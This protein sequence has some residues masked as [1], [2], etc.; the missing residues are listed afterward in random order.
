MDK[1]LFDREVRYN[2]VLE[3]IDKYK[4]PV[5]CGKVNYPG[6]NKN[7]REVHKAF[8]ILTKL[9]MEAFTSE[10]V[11]SRIIAGS[12]GP[13]HIMVLRMNSFKAKDIAVSIEEN[14]EIGRVFDIDIYMENGMS[15]SR[16]DMNLA[17]RKCIICEEDSRI[18]TKLSRHSLEEVLEAFNRKINSVNFC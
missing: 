5:L 4:L 6:N 9:L 17:S 10:A 1:L 2:E 3:L 11:V 12:D 18:C 16:S 14:N 7:N 13:A 15:I 8:N